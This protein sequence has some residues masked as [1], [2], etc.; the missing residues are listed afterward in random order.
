MAIVHVYLRALNFCG[1]ASDRTIQ[2][3]R[4]LGTTPTGSVSKSVQTPSSAKGKKRALSPENDDSSSRKRMKLDEDFCDTTVDYFHRIRIKYT[5]LMEQS[6]LPSAIRDLCANV[7]AAF[8]NIDSIPIGPLHLYVGVPEQR[9]GYPAPT[10]IV[11]GT[12][13]R[14]IPKSGKVK[15][16][17]E[18]YHFLRLPDIIDNINGNDYNLTPAHRELLLSLLT[19]A[20]ADRGTLSAT[21]SL[22]PATDSSRAMSTSS[23]GEFQLLPDRTLFCLNIDIR[24]TFTEFSPPATAQLLEAQR[25]ATISIFRASANTPMLAPT[26]SEFISHLEPA[27]PLPS[28]ILPSFVQPKGLTAKLYPFQLRTLYWLLGLEGEN[29]NPS[30]RAIEPARSVLEDLFWD[31]VTMPSSG[32]TR[33]INRLT[34]E[35]Y[36]ERPEIEQPRGGI[37]SEEPGL[38]KTLGRVVSYSV[39]SIYVLISDRMHRPYSIEST[40]GKNTGSSTLGGRNAINCVQSQGMPLLVILEGRL[41]KGTKSLLSS[42]RLRVY[43]LSGSTKLRSTPLPSEYSSSTVGRRFAN[44]LP[45]PPWIAKQLRRRSRKRLRVDPRRRHSKGS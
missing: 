3:G 31:Q 30:T 23:D 35:L 7:K 16:K 6:A 43:F 20:N 8:E 14:V 26:V 2:S 11:F 45:L 39:L 22:S 18:D 34:G 5:T 9:R 38:G 42:L 41:L 29:I 1:N 36:E 44:R 10:S 33:F 17:A 32:E 25:R 28:Q 19:L 37:L 24:F 13:H 15:M 4:T 21:L 40:A 27:P 12:L